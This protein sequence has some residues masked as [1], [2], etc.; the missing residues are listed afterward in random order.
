MNFRSIRFRI[1]AWYASLLALLLFLFG[2]FVYLTL[3]RFLERNLHDSLAKEAQTIGDALLSKI[4]QTGD[5]Y[6]ID[7]IEEHFAPRT[8][9]H[10]LRV[11]R[12]NGSVLYESG[13]P[14]DGTFDPS[15][16]YSAEIGTP[17]T[18]KDEDMPNGQRL[19]VYNMPY[20][21][22]GN[23]RY[24]VQAGA[25]NSQIAQ[26]LNSLLISL[27]IVLPLIVGISIVGGYLLLR[28]ALRP[29]RQ[30]A[31]VSE[32]NTSRNLNERI[33]AMDT[34]DEIERLTESLNRMMSRLEESFHHVQ[35][36][37]AD[38]SHE[39]RT[40]LAIL[41]AELE[42]LLQTAALTPE[43]QRSA[44][45]ALEEAERLSRIAEQLLEMTRLEA[46]ELLSA[47]TCFDFS[48]MAKQT[49]DQMRLLADE[50]RLDLNFQTQ[51]A[52]SVVGDPMRLRQVVVNLVDNAIKYTPSSGAIV[53]R[54][55]PDNSKAVLEV[56]DTG[57]GIP[58]DAIPY[59]FERFY[60]VD[61]ARSRGLGGTGLG[62]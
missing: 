60:R 42:D 3:Q 8:T 25:S 26:T 53:V 10:F 41:R 49:V 59:L 13:K 16:V 30:I 21:D 1:G 4:S 14:H 58:T 46:G 22:S 24:T 61:R 2:G 5:E 54:C 15:K 37:S 40:P 32:K 12:S 56:T 19:F 38:V 20:P 17:P 55:F 43:A 35:R 34:G 6:V 7:E 23:V 31:T 33:P 36:F 44:Q 11:T 47:S 50:K 45:S 29:L 62:L 52:A 48:E 57:I 28:S 39:I 27:S 9:N 18:W 51:V